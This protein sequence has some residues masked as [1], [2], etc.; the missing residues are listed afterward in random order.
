M[1]VL[2]LRRLEL[3][4]DLLGQDLSELDTPLVKGVDVPD[5]AFGK[6][7]VFVVCDQG[8]EGAWCDLLSED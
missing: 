7:Q 6:G 2:L 3:R 5:G 1:V 8:A 4:L